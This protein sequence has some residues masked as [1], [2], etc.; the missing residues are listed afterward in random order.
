MMKCTI[1]THAHATEINQ[2]LIQ[3]TPYRDIAG[4]F[5][6]SK[7]TVERH[8]MRCLPAHLVKAAEAEGVTDAS[9]LMARLR[10]LEQETRDILYEARTGV[11]HANCPKCGEAVA[12]KGG[13]SDI[14]L[15]AIGRLEAQLKLAAE[16][17]GLLIKRLDH[18]VSFKESLELATMEEVEA[19]L[20]EM[21]TRRAAAKEAR[22]V[23]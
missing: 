6:I 18:R 12:V 15:K 23:Q 7:S 3:S 13:N 1:C 21:E 17:A 14:A 4:R 20:A 19:L 10:G 16:L 5:G 11:K 9:S 8:R 22:L 2:L